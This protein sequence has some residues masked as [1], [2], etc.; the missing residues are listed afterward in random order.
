MLPSEVA[1]LSPRSLV[2]F[3][4][5]AGLEGKRKENRQST[6]GHRPACIDCPFPSQ[7]QCNLTLRS[8]FT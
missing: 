4:A 5:Y 2:F 8:N 1:E 3:V 6:V 7:T